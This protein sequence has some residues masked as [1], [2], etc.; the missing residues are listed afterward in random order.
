M[1]RGRSPGPMVPLALAAALTT[2][3][4]VWSWRGFV[5]EASDY[6]VPAMF[7]LLLL[8]GVGILCRAGRFPVWL[9][10]CCQLLAMLVFAN[11]LWGSSVLPWPSSV[12]ATAQVL[13]DGVSDS[14]RYAAP[15]PASV[16][17]VAALLVVGS[18]ACHV[19]VDLLAVSLARVP[20]AGLPLLMIYSLPLSILAQPVPW[21]TFVFGAGGF[22]LML[23]I[24][25]EDRVARWGRPVDVGPQ[26]IGSD[27]G[28]RAGR[29][30]PMTVGA[31][32]TA[33]AVMM[34]LLIPTLE[35][36]WFPGPGGV[37]GGDRTVRISN[38]M[39][40]MRRD[41]VQ[42]ADVPVVRAVT[43]RV[44][45]SYLR[46]A[47]L[48]SYTRNAW[49]PGGRD[50]PAD[51]EASGDLPG[52]VGLDPSVPRD[53]YPWDVTISN[54]L[55]SLWLP[56][57]LAVE[58]IEA[59][60]RWR[61]DAETLDVHAARDDFGTA[62]M[63]YSLVEMDVDHD[64]QRMIAAP[65]APFELASKYTKLP[66]DVPDMV[67]ELARDVTAGADSDFEKVVAL[68]DWFRSSGEFTYSLDRAPGTG[69][70]DLVAFLA[71]APGGRVGYCEQFSSAMA[72]MT[73]SLG[74]P[75][76]VAVGFLDSER[77]DDGWVFS[78]RDLHA[79]PEVYFEGSGWVYFEPT[80]ADRALS[81][82]NYT[83]LGGPGGRPTFGPT[84]GSAA[85][86]GEPT[87]RP[88]F[89]PTPSQGQGDGE[90]DG[91]LP[92][93]PFLVVAG[94]VLLAGLAML[95]LRMTRRGRT[96]R[97]WHAAADP[98]EAAWAELRETA[99]DLGVMWPA[100]RSPRTAGHLL[101]HKLAAEPEPGSTM[102]PRK[103]R[104]ANPEATA[105]LD[106]IVLALEESRYS[107]LGE[108]GTDA[109]GMRAATETCCRALRNGVTKG[110]RRR[111]DWLP[112]SVLSA[113]R[114]LRP[115]DQDQP[116]RAHQDVVDHVG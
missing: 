21:Y 48:T 15:V 24:H 56:T 33:L 98:A 20:L 105:A 10:V 13:V 27:L 83:D 86:A 88:D 28:V 53:T 63:S 44:A 42:D 38:P 31:G 1:T 8:A 68:Q 95:A 64:A 101:S 45:P 17:G 61:Y 5:V 34:P 11:L 89:E 2:W 94:A 104:D 39:T 67:R 23:E 22:L 59:G 107:P 78:S 52:P 100:G 43:D 74:I 6:L 37:G 71:D 26:P 75:T 57:P 72:I 47:V 81:A 16:T 93:L 102:R 54:D 4:T 35:L 18:M 90:Q 96:V 9:V 76:R 41:L 32:A 79:W 66:G 113:R 25:E 91:G 97:R 55:D 77:D 84:D 30:H 29:H 36:N 110:V 51:Q 46:V 106:R 19:L 108:P 12:E 14:R 80:P 85:G 73:R 69:T 49:T 40:D 112:R 3:L 92:L 65:Q 82:P 109:A 111:A 103:G 114:E 87:Q 70:D 7:G 116:V 58:S 99:I 60:E 115:S 50:L 62:G